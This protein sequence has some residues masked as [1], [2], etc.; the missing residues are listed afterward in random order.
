[1]YKFDMSSVLK[2]MTQKLELADTVGETIVR[3]RRVWD[4]VSTQCD[5]VIGKEFTGIFI[6]DPQELQVLILSMQW[7]LSIVL[8]SDPMNN[9]NFSLQ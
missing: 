3:L 2:Q 6:F 4:R 8:T 1:L 7:R 9:S 5:A